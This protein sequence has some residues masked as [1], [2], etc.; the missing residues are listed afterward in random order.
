MASVK[1]IKVPKEPLCSAC[2]D[3]AKIYYMKKWWCTTHTDLGEFNIKG[4]CKNDKLP[5]M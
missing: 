3:E 2:G 1:I 4:Y 5:K